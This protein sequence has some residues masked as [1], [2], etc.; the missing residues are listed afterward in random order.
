M[1]EHITQSGVCRLSRSLYEC[2]NH[3]LAAIAEDVTGE[4]HNVLDHTSA[5]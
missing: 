5:L 3:Q 1:A 2:H 4:L